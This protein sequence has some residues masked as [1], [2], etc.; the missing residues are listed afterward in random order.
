[1]IEFFIQ[2]GCVCVH[3]VEGWERGAD[4]AAVTIRALFVCQEFVCEKEHIS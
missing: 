4:P 2:R 3:A 1:M